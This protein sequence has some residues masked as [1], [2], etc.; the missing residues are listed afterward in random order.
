MV[1]PLPA[2]ANRE[3]ICAIDR[4]IDGIAASVARHPLDETVQADGLLAL[5]HLAHSN[6]ACARSSLVR[7]R[8]VRQR[9][10]RR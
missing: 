4:C 9:Q 8:R 7:H 2:D 5:A 1:L 6:G 3:R 10:K